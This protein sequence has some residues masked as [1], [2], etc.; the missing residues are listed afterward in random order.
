MAIM[1]RR[2]RSFRY[3]IVI[4][5]IIVCLQLGF[6]VVTHHFHLSSSNP[7][8]KA[9]GGEHKLENT[10][11]LTTTTTTTTTTPATTTVQHGIRLKTEQH[12]NT[13]GNTTSNWKPFKT[14]LITNRTCSQY[15]SLLILVNSA[16]AN[17]QRRNVIRKTW[18]FERAF[19]PRWTTVFLIGQTRNQNESNLLLK[20]DELYGDLV[21]ADY[22]DHYWNQTL[23]IQMGFDWAARYCKFSF[24]LKTDDDVFVNAEKL[25]SFLGEPTT[26][27][28][29]LYMGLVYRTPLANRDG[30]WKVSKEEYS[31]ERY[32]D[33]C[34]GLGYVLS[35][36]AL[37]SLVQTF[38][39]LPYFRLDDVYVGMLADRAGI[40]AINNAG[41]EH[42][43]PAAAEQCI[44]K[45][46][47][48]LRH[49]FFGPKGSHG[50]CVVEIFNR[51][52]KMIEK[53][54]V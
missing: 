36:D 25:V 19:K 1:N 7:V 24:L 47:T 52:T 45:K 31:K 27:K 28:K 29:S 50:D 48:L 46:S 32:P 39:L 23:K 11:A 15:Y 13:K 16:P 10:T 54:R 17:L 49:G 14:T 53:P 3:F 51:A 21:R 12:N 43:L 18:A 4:L 41:F 2:S 5:T 42:F 44:P 30:K 33:F 9:L 37:I 38:A 34:F 35:H 8:Y 40:K 20:E 6:Y 22:Y 26:P